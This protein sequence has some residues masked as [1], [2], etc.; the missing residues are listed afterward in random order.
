MSLTVN[1]QTNDISNATGAILFNGV[2]VGGDNSPVWYGARSVL[3]GG[4]INFSTSVNTIQ[5]FAN[6]TNTN[7]SDF[8]DLTS[9]N[10]AQGG[11]SNGTRALFAGGNGTGYPY[12][13]NIDYITI[14]TTGNAQDFGDLN[15]NS[16][17]GRKDCAGAGNGTY[18]FFT[19]S[20]SSTFKQIDYVTVATT[21]NAQ[22]WGDLSAR[23]YKNW[24]A[25]NADRLL[26]GY[27]VT[28]T[29]AIE[30]VSSTTPG[31]TSD[32]GTLITPR[33]NSSAVSDTTRAVW[34]GG[35]QLSN[36]AQ[37]NSLSYVTI[38][39]TGNATDFGD[40]TVVRD[41]VSTSS[42]ATRGFW[43]GGASP[44]KLNSIDVVTIQTTGNATDFGDLLAATA[45]VAGT[46][47]T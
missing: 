21:G 38:A 7:A 11:A 15:T 19:G 28:D 6:S 35:I 24:S 40:L 20:S 47:G 41:E 44:T 27:I 46:A 3:A 36:N 32:F 17:L 1:H 2:A 23:T 43:C 25:A 22:D 37:L 39:T 5:Y 8:G 30:Y 18:A 16:V 33:Q 9:V 10:Y 13:V 12:A 42:N 34:G 29:D 31:N 45:Y 4:I 26:V 14:A